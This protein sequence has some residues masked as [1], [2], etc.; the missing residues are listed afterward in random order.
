MP[1]FTKGGA[2]Q[3]PF[4]VNR[5][6]RSTVGVK[7]TSYSVAK[8]SVPGVV[9]AD[10]STQK[11]LQPGTVMAKITSGPDTGKIGPFQAAGTAD[12]WTVTPTGTWSGGTF[13]V[14][15]NGQTTAPIAFG[16]TAATIQTAVQAL[17]SVGAGNLLV[18]G[19]PQST[20][21]TVYTAA[22]NLQGSVALSLNVSL[23][24]GSSPVAGAVH[25]TTGIAGSL[26][27]R[28]STA[29]IVGLND[30]FLPWQLLN[31][32]EQIAVTYEA[33]AVQ[34]WCIEL[35]AAGTPQACQ[36]ATATA[37]VAQKSMSLTFY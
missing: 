11:I 34:A 8:N 28:S 15:V 26:D 3:T 4:G 27:G 35:T 14:T 21:P 10:G 23:V 25:T 9:I 18:T 12:V 19:G 29:G 1:S 22:G 13:T 33:T 31:H 24:T 2:L 6:L 32:D 37:M 17:S 16:A 7:K 36:N 20:T 30:T 5:Y